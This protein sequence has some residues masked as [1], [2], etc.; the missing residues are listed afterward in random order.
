MAEDQG[1]ATRLDA[2]SLV[3][4]GCR[5]QVRTADARYTEWRVWKGAALA[6]D[7]SAAGLHA[8]ELYDHTGDEG[9]GARAFDDFEFVNLAYR[10]ERAPQ[11]AQLA[12]LLR[13]QFHG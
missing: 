2:S 9:A 10:L 12:A 5:L 11:V 3:Q 7:W 13:A 8:C 4:H 6:A 1:L